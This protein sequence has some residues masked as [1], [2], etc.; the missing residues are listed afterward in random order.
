MSYTRRKTMKSRSVIIALLSVLCIAPVLA[1]AE[2]QDLITPN[3]EAWDKLGDG[4]WQV[5]E[6]GT[7]E[8]Y[9]R[10]VTKSLFGDSETITKKQFEE[11]R[12]VQS[13]LYT[14]KDYGEYDLHVEYRVRVSGNSGVSLRDPTRAKFAITQP[15]DYQNTPAHHGYEIQISGHAG[16]SSPSGSLYTFVSAKDGHQ[17]DGEWNTFDIESR[18]DVI[19]VRLNGQLVTEHAGDPKRPTVGP[20]GLQLHDQFNSIMFRNIRIMEIAA[21]K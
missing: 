1:A 7:L 12:G 17:K 11:W 10:P 14:K 3:L 8:G 4:I 9:R 19:R 15:A 6:D 13:W 18:A 2:W 20:I 5:S 21:S 16:T